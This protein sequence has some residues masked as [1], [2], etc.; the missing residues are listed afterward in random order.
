MVTTG[1]TVVVTG[2]TVVVTGTVTRNVPR[3]LLPQ[4]SVRNNTVCEPGTAPAG[5]VTP[6]D[7]A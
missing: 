1:G 6:T 5:T 3:A 4:H 2:G 7:P